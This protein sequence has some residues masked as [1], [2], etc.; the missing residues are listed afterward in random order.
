MLKKIFEMVK[1]TF[2]ILVEGNGNF[3]RILFLWGVVPNVVLILFFQ[4][5]IEIFRFRFFTL[6]I[7]I[8]IIVYFLWHIFIVR[9][10]LKI[11]PQYKVVKVK[12]KDL[13]KGKTKEEIAEMKKE[14]RKT[15][16][17]KMF[18]LEAWDSTPNYVIVICLDAYTVLTQLQII[19]GIFKGN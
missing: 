15:A 5:K 17:K 8:L 2:K 11:Q 12:K 14:E 9:K 18:L 13:Y 6:F 3:N 16:V 7:C 10:T 1:N 19:F 4:R